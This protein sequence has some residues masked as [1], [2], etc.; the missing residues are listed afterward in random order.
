MGGEDKEGKGDGRERKEKRTERWKE[1]KDKK[2]EDA[3]LQRDC[4]YHLRLDCTTFFWWAASGVS[5]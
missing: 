4:G 3:A 5:E 2:D 1:Q